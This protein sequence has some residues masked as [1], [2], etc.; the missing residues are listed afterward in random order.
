MI[1]LAIEDA[2][3]EKFEISVGI[4]EIRGV[5]QCENREISNEIAEVEDAI[6]R[7]YDIDEVKDIRTIRSQRD[8]FWRMDVD[9]TKVRP[10][11]EALLRRIL[12]NKGL[13][14]VSP[15]VDAYNLAS[16]KTLLTFS[17]FDLARIDPPLKVRFARAGEKVMLIGNRRKELTGKEMV[18][19]DSAKIL[20]VYVHGDVEETKVTDA[21]TDVLLVAYG[22]PG[23]SHD[24][25]REGVRIA[26]HYIMR[27]AGGEMVTNEVYG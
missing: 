24:E 9:P 12:L 3:R 27:F 10:A 16:V 25:L 1:R 17:A 20:C 8:F 15:I 26:S 18:L 22:I 23:I 14:R 4:A 13:P 19:T 2:V 11:S 5:R 6:K 7:S 21:T